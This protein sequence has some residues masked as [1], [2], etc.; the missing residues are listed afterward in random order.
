M[1][2]SYVASKSLVR[3]KLS[4]DTNETNTVT[5]KNSTYTCVKQYIY[6]YNMYKYQFITSLN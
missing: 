6:E 4:R 1:A 2:K 5:Y 3:D